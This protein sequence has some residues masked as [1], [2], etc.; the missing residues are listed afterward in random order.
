MRVLY[1]HKVRLSSGYTC[2]CVDIYVCVCQ[3]A[4]VNQRWHLCKQCRGLQPRTDA[5]HHSHWWRIRWG[6]WFAGNAPRPLDRNVA[7]FWVRWF[8]VDL[9]LF[10]HESM[11]SIL[12]NCEWQIWTTFALKCPFLTVRMRGLF[13]ANSKMF[14]QLFSIKYRKQELLCWVNVG[15]GVIIRRSPFG[16]PFQ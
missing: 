14:I 6:R 4:C 2:L 8:F 10:I 9:K 5:S 16:K 1:V 11:L 7:Q 13:V 3:C 15:T 12:I